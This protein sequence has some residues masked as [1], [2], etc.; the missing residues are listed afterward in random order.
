[1]DLAR[2]RSGRDLK[3][4]LTSELYFCGVL[5]SSETGAQMEEYADRKAEEALLRYRS[6]LARVEALELA[7]K[8]A[9]QALLE[10]RERVEL[11]I[12]H[13]QTAT[14]SDL[15]AAGERAV[16][17]LQA[18]RSTLDTA[19]AELNSAFSALAALDD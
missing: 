8:T 18:I 2:W 1:L 12:T 11:S 5:K 7:E 17:E 10:W 19:I 13:E 14:R 16:S 15:A 3:R 9:R 6:A 4:L